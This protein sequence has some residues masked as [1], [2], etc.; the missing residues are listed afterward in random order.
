[1]RTQTFTLQNLLRKSLL[2]FGIMLLCSFMAPSLQAQESSEGRTVTGV[3][4]RL[5]GPLMGASIVL[6]GTSIGIVSN[7]DGTFTFPKKLK[8][9]DVLVVSY[10]GYKNQQVTIG[11]STTFIKPFLEDI[12]VILR[13][14]LRTGDTAATS[15]DVN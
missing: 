4:T 8:E 15:M 1:M 3:V 6:E 9:N 11:N 13:G 2:F 5:D 10:L 7:E 12:P 14:A